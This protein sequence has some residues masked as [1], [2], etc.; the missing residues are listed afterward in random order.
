MRK[1]VKDIWD[2]LGKDEPKLADFKPFTVAWVIQRVIED[3]RANPEMKQH[4]ESHLYT[5]RRLQRSPLGAKDARKLS[6]QDVIEYAKERRKDVCAATVNQDIT[7][8]GGS[9]DHA[10][11]TWDDCEQVTRAPL[12]AARP[13]LFKHKLVGKS[14]PRKRRPTDEEI[15]ALLAYF[16]KQQSHHC[17]KVNM[18]QVV[19]FGLASSR[20]IGE[21][22]RITHGDVDYVNKV[23]WVRDM[24]HPTRKK[25]N[26]KKFVLWPEL[27]EIIKRQPRLDPRNPNERIFPYEKKT[28]SAR[29]TLAKKPGAATPDGIEN[30]RL[31]DNRRDCISR[32]LLVM[33]PEDVRLAVSGHDNTKI[34]ESNYDG[35]DTSEVMREK[36]AHLM[37]PAPS[38]EGSTA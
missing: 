8:L 38:A 18:E 34:L 35:R 25:G 1:V 36:Y 3:V 11:S 32:Y 20:R 13:Y 29:Y 23:Y 6:R 19:L 24:K 14:V 2:F 26:D 37:K 21:I 16:R 12:E 31:H 5:L 27:E 4:G 33:P 30:L 7:Y 28:C 22:C 10:N 17:T 9:L 15:H